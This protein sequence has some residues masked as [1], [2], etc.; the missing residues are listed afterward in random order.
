VI[1]A[2]STLKDEKAIEKLHR[3]HQF[4][5]EL[6]GIT[7]ELKAPDIVNNLK[8]ENENKDFWATV[9]LQ[10]LV[11]WRVMKKAMNK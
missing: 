10:S 1:D 8:E 4:Q 3:L 5:L 11:Q 2:V 6:R 7:H 9:D